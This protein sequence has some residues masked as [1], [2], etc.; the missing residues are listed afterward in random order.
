MLSAVLSVL[1][2]LGPV[3]FSQRFLHTEPFYTGDY[4]AI[5][6]PNRPQRPKSSAM[7]PPTEILSRLFTEA[8]LRSDWFADS[9]LAQI[10]LAQISQITQGIVSSVGEYQSIEDVPN[11]FVLTFERGTVATHLSLNAQGQITGLLFE[12][13]QLSLSLDE[14]LRELAAL[15]GEVHVL[16]TR[17]GTEVAELNAEQSLAVG[18]TFKLLILQVLRNQIAAGEHQWNEVVTLKDEWKS[19]PSGVL[20]DWPVDTSITL[21]SLATLMISQSDN[22]ATD[23]LLHIVGREAVEALSERN[24]PFLTTR[25]AFVLKDPVNQR[26]LSRWRRSD[27]KR[28]LVSA[29]AALPLPDVNIFNGGP[30]AIDVEWFFTASELCAAMDSVADLPLMSVNPGLVDP[31]AWEKVSFKGG[32]EPGVENFTTYLVDQQGPLCVTATWNNP[33]G[34]DEL[35]FSTLYRSLIASL[36]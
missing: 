5:A 17:N 25:E 13:P 15:P 35:K 30:Q 4:G 29:I 3:A 32:S 18:S 12:T 36:R 33:E 7:T 8:Q 9:F 1:F 23:H 22:T 26:V 24:R 34:I 16:A 19:L 27:E 21:E 2:W 28:S 6:A 10:S 31:T 20:Q 11:G 14:A